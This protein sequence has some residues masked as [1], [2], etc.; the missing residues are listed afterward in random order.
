MDLLTF[1]LGILAS[2]VAALVYDRMTRPELR[3]AIDESGRVRGEAQGLHEFHHLIVRN[4]RAK[5][6]YASRRPAWSAKAHIEV[7]DAD[8][9]RVIKSPVYAR[10]TSQPEPL[11]P[12]VSADLAAH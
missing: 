11:I 1:S 9:K 2:G 4:E 12:V 6:L 7:F 3:I 10:W 8:G 5:L